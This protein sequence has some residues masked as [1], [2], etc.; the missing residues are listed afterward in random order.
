MMYILLAQILLKD[1]DSEG[2][3]DSGKSI[4]F[5]DVHGKKVRW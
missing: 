4:A 1:V 3:V 5:F 2:E